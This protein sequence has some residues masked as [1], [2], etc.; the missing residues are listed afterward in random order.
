[1]T[2][3]DPA[4]TPTAPDEQYAKCVTE[5]LEWERI[6]F[7]RDPNRAPTATFWATCR[8]FSEAQADAALYVAAPDTKRERDELLACG[9]E[10][11]EAMALTPHD[12]KRELRAFIKLC[13]AIERC[14]R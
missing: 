4:D 14:G 3:T 5:D 11:T 8:P 12:K 2:K 1:M 10:L 7:G 9:T 13:A 6:D